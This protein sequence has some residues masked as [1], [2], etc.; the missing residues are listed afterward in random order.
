[1]KILRR[2]LAADFTVT[3]L[4]ALFM[5]TFVLS[6][7]YIFK[8]I[9]IIVRGVP[10]R[11]VLLVLGAS[12]PTSLKASIPL[13]ALV[14]CLLLFGR[15]SSDCEI[16]AMKACGVR[17]RDVA[18]TMFL[19][20]VLLV[21]FSLYVNH[22][23]EPKCH[24]IRRDTVARMGGMTAVTML[25]NGRFH[26]FGKF[27]LY[28]G[29]HDE[30][31]LENIRIYDL[32]NPDFKQE[33]RAQRGTI[34]YVPGTDHLALD[35][36]DVRLDPYSADSESPGTV[37]H[38]RM[39]L[40]NFRQRGRYQADEED[41][42]LDELLAKLIGLRNA[43][44]DLSE[45]DL[46]VER[47]AYLFELNKRTSLA[48]APLAF[49]LL[50]IPLGIQSH[51]KESSVGIAMSLGIMLLFFLLTILAESTANRPHWR[52]DIIVWSPTIV[53]LIAGVFLSRRMH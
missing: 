36:E 3:L 32:R 46:K 42:V 9:D 48:L 38:L 12:I 44:P 37:G 28:V 50:G 17:M 39:V 41:M 26:N 10:W 51:R 6:V 40:E 7:G 23:I 8:I 20:T 11:P 52:P 43:R 15:L 27:T 25:E 47:M 18:R 33:I 31:R 19:V 22:Y 4:V 5:V 30:G 13:S 24:F 49:V 35:M 53:F 29:N 16:V 21:A 34:S 2:Y 1:L 14:G 45:E